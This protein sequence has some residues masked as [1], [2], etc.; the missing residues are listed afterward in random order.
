VSTTVIK[1]KYRTMRDL[2]A[3]ETSETQPGLDA[4]PATPEDA[5]ARDALTLENEIEWI[6]GATAQAY[7]EK[8]H[9]NNRNMRRDWLQTLARDMRM[10]NWKLSGDPIRFDRDGLLIDGQHRLAALVNV[11]GR[12][13]FLVLR[14]V[15]PEAMAIIDTG[16][17]RRAA[18]ALRVAGHVNTNLL[19]GA[20][21]LLLRI[22]EGP[23]DYSQR[24][25]VTH[26]QL[27][28]VV[29]RHP[30]L[31]HSIQVPRAIKGVRPTL[32]VAMHYIGTYL[33]AKAEAADAFVKVFN[34]G[35][36]AY[37][38]DPAHKLRERWLHERGAAQRTTDA[39][40]LLQIAHVW[41]HFSEWREVGLLKFP[42]SVE[43][44]GLNPKQI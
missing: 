17:S 5:L 13:P 3:D 7:L 10:G 16:R 2:L 27:L 9:P 29:K 34:T 37:H 42:N 24:R 21:R 44:K 26:S 25:S 28:E 35:I 8:N 43:I 30:N 19:A 14:N 11:D 1:K 15:D 31:S 22:K 41:N 18:D 40:K 33:L 20:A 23:L 4:R 38:N 39:N 32:L 6:D 12:F 36:P